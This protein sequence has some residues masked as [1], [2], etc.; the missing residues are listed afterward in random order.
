V[1]DGVDPDDDPLLFA[2]STSPVRGTLT[3][4]P[5][6]LRYLPLPDFNGQDS[7]TF[8]VTDG[9]L[10]SPDATVNIAILP[11]NDPP[12]A[13]AQTVSLL[14]DEP[15]AIV[16]TGADLEGSPLTYSI[17]QWPE[18]GTLTGSPPD[19]VYTPA[20]DF[21]GQDQFQFLVHDGELDSAPVAVLLSIQPV[22]DPPVVSAG[23]DQAFYLDQSGFL[24][25]SLSDDDM[26][27]GRAARIPLVGLERPRRRLLRAPRQSHRPGL[28]RCPRHLCPAPHRQRH[29][30]Q[31]LR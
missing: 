13:D 29:R 6:R 26:P 16:L 12:I 31:R 15:I 30:T 18:H 25:A 10:T 14:E 9:E 22:N 5:P 21:S 27:P 11:V 17:V 1:L 19:L 4:D 23:L 20:P 24:A 3:G 7:F 28:V 2:V 8:T